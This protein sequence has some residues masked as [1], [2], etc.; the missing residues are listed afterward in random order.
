HKGLLTTSALS[1]TDGSSNC[2]RSSPRSYDISLSLMHM[3]WEAD[4]EL[5]SSPDPGQHFP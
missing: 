2:P 3:T 5:S 1:G 4:S